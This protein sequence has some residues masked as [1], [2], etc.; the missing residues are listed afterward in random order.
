[1]PGDFLSALKQRPLL[2]DGATGTMLQRLGLKPGGCPDE[3]SLKNPELVKKVHSLYIEIGS[4]IVTTNTFGANRLKLKE[5]A[6]E[7]RLNEINIAAAKCARQA[8]GNKFVA[9]GL[10]PTGSFIE[11]VGDME[12]DAILEV[13]TE[14]ANALKQGGADLFIIET[15]MDIKEMKAAIIACKSTGLPVVATMTFDETM[16]TVLGT[17]PESF[18]IMAES[19]GADCIGANCSLGIE[20]IYKALSAMSRVVD[21]PLIAQPN[22]GLPVLKGT[23]T[24]FPASPEDMAAYVP[25][26][27]EIGVKILGGCC[28]TTPD[29]IKKMGDVFKSLK[30]AERK[31]HGFTALSGRTSYTLFGAGLP[32]IVIGERINPTGR[33]VLAQEIKEGKTTGIRNEAR[34]Q[35]EAGAHALDV[36][37]GVPGIDEVEAMRKAVFAVN[38]NTSLPIVIDSSS[39]E[40]VIAGL[41]A[42]DGKPLI[43]SISGEEKKLSTIMPLA[44]EYGAA[45]LGLTLDDDGIP[46]TAEG[47]LK[48][49][50]KILNR[51]T[52]IGIRKED[53]VIDCLAMTVSA[54]PLSAIE[55]LKAI[56]LIKEELGLATVLGVSNISFG[57]PAREVI[58]SNFLTMALA[59]GLD[60]SIINPNNKA[61][62]DA[63]HAS[64]V[65]LNKDIRAE[66]YIKRHQAMA[67]QSAP[68]E[69]AQVQA[70][71]A[72][73]ADKLKRAVIQGDEENITSLVDEALKEGWD[74][75]KVSNDA[76]VPGLEEVGRLFAANKYYLPQVM[77]SAETM[78]KAFA[79]LKSEFGERKGPAIAKVLLATVEGDIHD[80]GKNIVSTLLENHGFDVI[81]LGKNVPSS[82]IIEEAVKHNVDIVGLSALM[83]TTVLEM[84]K[85][86][87]ELKERGIKTMTIVGG[88]VVTKEFSEKIGA[89]EYGGDALSAI[90]K[91][92]KMVKA[93]KA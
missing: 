4:D 42:C 63:Y 20:G 32:A 29:H 81:D 72:G 22:A 59:A 86:I 75:I 64:L 23:E 88:A 38:E 91:M 66:R 44:K 16:R 35:T 73:I 1:M 9:G 82:K 85:V 78:K 37:V 27:V 92:K 14:Q 65:L 31:P 71:P 90:E 15:M 8:A 10:G 55:T 54:A 93:V 43:N 13:Y 79:R 46:E 34:Q 17:P 56:R 39:P 18:A 26:L 87:K 57:L 61:M 51:A 6:L 19:L 76:L 50:E 47:R 67:A 30:P 2:F 83:T 5:Y 84:D 24:V 11:P 25:K 80:I 58:N 69:A 60:C 62:M 41:K 49:A 33:K 3:L 12:F 28:G 21:I 52:K 77:L 53:L 7:G 68:Q 48:V 45:L 74:P 40:A 89:D 36:N 70:A